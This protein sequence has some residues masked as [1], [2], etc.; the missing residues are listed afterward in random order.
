[1]HQRILLLTSLIVATVSGLVYQCNSVTITL[2]LLMV[3]ILLKLKSF[4]L[5]LVITMITLP[6]LSYFIYDNH[7][8]EQI[9]KMQ[10][11][12]YVTGYMFADDI[13]VD[14]DNLKA[15]AYL[16]H[17]EKVKLYWK[18]PTQKEK[19]WLE[20]NTSTL[21]FHA[22][23]KQ[24]V[25]PPATNFNQ[26][27]AQKFY[28]TQKIVHQATVQQWSYSKQSDDNFKP[29][30]LI[31]NLRQ[32]HARA[33]GQVAQLPQP[34]ANYAQAL[35]LGT[36]PKSLYSDNPAIST[37]ELIHLFSVS[38]FQVSYI[39]TTL[40]SLARRLRMIKEYAVIFLMMILIMFY[41]F[42]GA[43]AILVRA[44][45]AGELAL[46]SLGYKGFNLSATSIWAISLLASLVVAPQLLLTLGGQLSFL[47]TFCLLFSRHLSFWQSNLL[48]GIVMFPLIT[49]QQFTW[50]LLEIPINFLAIPLFEIIIVPSI[51]VGV[52]QI[53]FIT[54]FVN[55]LIHLFASIIDTVASLPLNCV[56]GKLAWPFVLLL[57]ILAMLSFTNK[58]TTARIARMTWLITLILGII[59][60][61]FPLHGE[62]SLFDI[63]Q[64]DAILVRLPFNQNVTLIDTGGKVNFGEEN[65][66]RLKYSRPKGETVIINYLHSRGISKVNQLVLT[67]QDQDHI[68]DAY[69][70]LQK[71]AVDRVIIPKGMRQQPAFAQKIKPYLKQRTQVI[72]TTDNDTQQNM[73]LKVLY[74]FES[75]HGKNEDCIALYGEFGGKR[76]L[77]SGD[78]D[79]AGEE[80][81]CQKYPNLKLD[82]LKFGHHGSK[83]STSS[84]AI[85]Q[86]CPQYG[87]V[88]SGR[89]NRYH[90]PHQETLDL[91]QQ[92]KLIVYNTQINGM[93]TYVPR[94]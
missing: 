61:R 20:T 40:M 42:V 18:V 44:V 64:G 54:S 35:L 83:T 51:F 12:S 21:Y 46:L 48:M 89:N 67:H 68:G 17:H 53:P 38:R 33:L 41:I 85:K 78:L 45:V 9:N 2:F 37:L 15:V 10:P 47:L 31:D 93:I 5:L 71:M 81:I 88:S 1:M 79:K 29:N 91:A 75:G 26:F 4:K 39:I 86:W 50:H 57:L 82:I 73:P 16:R 62:V 11:D 59:W 74:P 80:K 56:V 32:W 6:F 52:W 90:H 84:E 34:L 94:L 23:V 13:E 3:G 8:L 72:E 92:Q 22:N 63:G 24:T 70:I 49:H 65:W 76:F 77:T 28:K 14:G 43:P 30:F 36:T 55:Q 60:V 25:I 66:Q 27:D 58:K 19:Q 7:Q 87:L 69:I